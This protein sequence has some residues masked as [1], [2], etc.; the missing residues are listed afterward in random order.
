MKK[1]FAS[2]LAISFLFLASCQKELDLLPTNTLKIESSLELEIRGGGD[3]DHSIFI[4]EKA[5]GGPIDDNYDWECLLNAG[6]FS[7]PGTFKYLKDKNGKEK[8]AIGAGLEDGKGEFSQAG[9]LA[10]FRSDSSRYFIPFVEGG[11]PVKVTV[12][13]EYIGKVYV[14]EKKFK[15]W[16][17]PSFEFYCPPALTPAGLP[18]EACMEM[19]AL[20]EHLETGELTRC[21]A[22]GITQLVFNGKLKV[23]K[24]L[25]GDMGYL[26]FRFGIDADGLLTAY[27]LDGKVLATFLPAG[28]DG[29]QLDAILV[30]YR[31][32]GEDRQNQALVTIAKSSLVVEWGGFS[33]IEE[34]SARPADCGVDE[35]LVCDGYSDPGEIDPAG[36]LADA[37]ETP[38]TEIPEA[39]MD[40]LNALYPEATQFGL[41]YYPCLGGG[42][43]LFVALREDGCKQLFGLFDGRYLEKDGNPANPDDYTNHRMMIGVKDG[44]WGWYIQFRGSSTLLFRPWNGSGAIDLKVSFNGQT[45][46]WPIKWHGGGDK[47]ELLRDDRIPTSIQEDGQEIFRLGISIEFMAMAKALGADIFDGDPAL[48][49]K[50]FA[51]TRDEQNCLFIIQTSSQRYSLDGIDLEAGQ[52]VVLGIAGDQRT[53]GLFVMNSDGLYRRITV[54]PSAA[55]HTV[56]A[57]GEH[58]GVKLDTR[59]CIH[60]IVPIEAPQAPQRNFLAVG[61]KYPNLHKRG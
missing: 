49:H 14:D 47:L 5:L 50:K 34:E 17:T 25:V 38:A 19:L 32:D 53:Y 39:M 61:V 20:F 29:A 26:S 8:P 10:F 9:I 59:H 60:G 27:G 58:F 46:V 36:C 44:K 57:N 23:F 28:C 3:V 7:L 31:R 40:A 22:D 35:P 18:L 15:S 42:V 1:A 48:H 56:R 4:I 11:V 13:G 45:F 54:E 52:Y 43:N 6:N 24:T 12:D 21:E 2:L 51:V 55:M 16:G 41:R 37:T 33:T 30:K